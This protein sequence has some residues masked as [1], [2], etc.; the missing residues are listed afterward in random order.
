VFGD[1]ETALAKAQ[2][3]A[4]YVIV[5]LLA[6]D[7]LISILLLWLAASPASAATEAVHDLFLQRII[8]AFD[9]RPLPSKPFEETEKFKLGRALFF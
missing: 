3:I 5:L 8:R 1:W 7:F 6:G 2:T 4:L 9:L